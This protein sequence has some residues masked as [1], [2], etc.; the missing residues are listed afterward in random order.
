MAWSHIA[1]LRSEPGN[2]SKVDPEFD[3]GFKMGFLG[4]WSEDAGRVF[5]GVCNPESL[6][7]SE[8]CHRKNCDNIRMPAGFQDCKLPKKLVHHFLI[9]LLLPDAFQGC[10]GSLCFQ[11]MKGFKKRRDASNMNIHWG[12]FGYIFL[13]EWRVCKGLCKDESCNSGLC[14]EFYGFVIRGS[15][16]ISRSC[17]T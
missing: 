3:C 1:S 9:K 11:D 12:I 2:Q 8:H 17:R 4:L 7:A 5:S 16:S 6:P 10:W 13:A 14:S 15:W